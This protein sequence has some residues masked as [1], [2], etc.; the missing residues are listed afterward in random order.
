MQVMSGAMEGRKERK[1]GMDGGGEGLNGELEDQDVAEDKNKMVGRTKRSGTGNVE[2]NGG[3]SESVQCLYC[4]R[5][6]T[7]LTPPASSRPRRPLPAPSTADRP[8]PLRSTGLLN[9]RQTAA[10]TTSSATTVFI[11]NS[12]PIRR[13]AFIAPKLVG[14]R[15]APSPLGEPALVTDMG[16]AVELQRRAETFENGDLLVTGYLE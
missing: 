12:R 6:P 2:K 4:E 11:P 3:D 9:D 13:H 15:E 5:G 14:G 8:P 1:S 16:H 7:V 10:M